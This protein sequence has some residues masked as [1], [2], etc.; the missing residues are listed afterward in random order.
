MGPL[1]IAA[2]ENFLRSFAA[3]LCQRLSTASGPIPAARGGGKEFQRGCGGA[4]IE[5]EDRGNTPRQYHAQ[6]GPAL[7][8][9]S[10]ALRGAKQ[11]RACRTKR[12]SEK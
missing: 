12:R 6:A 10:G 3:S 8:Q 2:Q 5:R 7:G 4:G 11:H 1:A 9:R